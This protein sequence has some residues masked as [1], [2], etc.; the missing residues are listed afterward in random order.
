MVN[1]T[2]KYFDSNETKVSNPP[3]ESDFI[4]G[5]ISWSH[6]NATYTL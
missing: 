2:V 1:I 6:N 4:R 5:F 3:T